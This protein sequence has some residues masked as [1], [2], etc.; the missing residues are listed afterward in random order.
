MGKKQAKNLHNNMGKNRLTLRDTIVMEK[1]RNRI[2][3][4]PWDIEFE[5][6][7]EKVGNDTMGK[8]YIS[9]LHDM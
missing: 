6:Y 7:H 2:C 3:M 4:I 8:K 9:N 5:R 1:Y